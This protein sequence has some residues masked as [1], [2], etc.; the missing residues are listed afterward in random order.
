ML[1]VITLL[2]IWVSPP[3]RPT[4]PPPPTYRDVQVEKIH[5]H[6]LKGKLLEQAAWPNI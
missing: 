2:M 1:W 4:F 6:R 3:Q 5:D